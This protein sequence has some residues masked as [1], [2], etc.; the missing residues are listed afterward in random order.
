MNLA[1]RLCA[2]LLFSNMIGL[3][4]Q[5][6]PVYFHRLTM[7]DGLS[8]NIVN[9]A[10]ED[11][12]GFMW[13]ATDYG[14]NRFDGTDF[15]VFFPDGGP[16]GVSS[17]SSHIV[18]M[19]K[20]EDGKIW[21][22][23]M[24]GV[25]VFDTD[26]ESFSPFDMKTSDGHGPVGKITSIVRGKD[27]AIWV[28]DYASGIFRYAPDTGTL[29]RY[30]SDDGTLK[31]NDVMTICCDKDGTVWTGTL[32][33]DNGGLNR[34][35]E[36]SGAF[37]FNE[38][39]C[40]GGVNIIAETNTND[41]LVGMPKFG[42]D[43][44]NRVTG[45]SRHI[46]VIGKR[47]L[48]V[49]DIVVDGDVVWIATTSGLIRYDSGTEECQFM[50]SRPGIDN[51]LSSDDVVDIFRDSRG[52]LWFCTR[53]K[54]VN[55]LPYD[56]D[57]FEQ[58]PASYDESINS[59]QVKSFAEDSDGNIWIATR[60]GVCIFDP[61]AKRFGQVPHRGGSLHG[62]DV[63]VMKSFG[64]H[65]LLIG[66]FGRGLDKL[67]LVTGEVKLYRR[68]LNGLGGL[69]DDSVMS[70]CVGAEG[71]LLVGTTRGADILRVGDSG[72]GVLIPSSQNELISDIMEDSDFNIW[73]SSYGNGVYVL[74]P[75]TNVMENIRND[76]GNPERLASNM[77]TGLFLDSAS[78]IWVLTEGG[79]MTRMGAD[80]EPPCHFTVEDGLPNNIVQKMLED[81][82]G[83]LWIS[84]YDGLSCFDPKTQLFTNYMFSGS[85]VSNQFHHD[86]GL[87]SSDGYM[88]FGTND[89]FIRFR[90][91]N[92]KAPESDGVIYFT[93]L[94]V[95]DEAVRVGGKDSPLN[96]S[97]V[98]TDKIVL[99]HKQNTLSLTF[100]RLDIRW[101][102]N[103]PFLYKLEGHDPNWMTTNS[104]RISY[105]N[106]PSGKYRLLVMDPSF[107]ED[108]SSGNSLAI[109]IKPSPWFSWYAKFFYALL[110]A[111]ALYLV[112]SAVMKKQEEKKK[113]LLEELQNKKEKMLY[114]TKLAFFTGLA[115]EIKTPL[116]LVSSPFELLMSPDATKEEKESCETV[117]KENLNRLTELT[118]QML[119]ISLVEREGVIL[120]KAPTDINTLLEKVLS[121][122]KISFTQNALTVETDFPER[123][124]IANVDKE[125][126]I[127]IF[128][129]LLGNAEK[130]SAGKI[131]VR[132][133]TLGDSMRLS[134]WNNGA[135]IA[136]E[137]RE[138]IFETFYQ[139]PG[140]QRHGGVGVGLSLVKKYVSL[141][142]GKVYV[143]P[144]ASEGTEF[145][146]EIPLGMELT[147][148]SVQD[149]VSLDE[150]S[151]VS[152][153]SFSRHT[154][155]IVDDNKGMTKFLKA[156]FSKR[157]HVITANDGTTAWRL[158]EENPIDLVI[159]DV[160]M[161]DVDG[162]SLCRK[163]KANASTRTIPVLL[164]TAKTDSRS[165]LEGVEAGADAYIEKPF[166][167]ELLMAQVSNVLD[168]VA[169]YNARSHDASLKY[170]KSEAYSVK[171]EQFVKK[172]YDVISDNL[173]EQDLDIGF[174]ADKMNTS[175]SSLYRI[176]KNVTGRSP[177]EIIK[178]IRLDKA[179]SLLREG[180]MRV[181]EVCFYVGYTS[182]SYFAKSF[183]KKFGVLPK[184]YAQSFSPDSVSGSPDAA[185]DVSRE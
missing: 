130:Y 132:L 64:K 11:D 17:L 85:P 119:D 135:E 1:R 124:V 58:Y 160:M 104:N 37:V 79:G 25:F 114:D 150:N 73:M 6:T 107:S 49:N 147:G 39:S 133:S 8:H 47:D 179:A 23:T 91:E 42:V 144:E 117:I 71:N 120:N 2:I 57:S 126:F 164:L 20:V 18:S 106:L 166:S 35:D 171:D 102:D 70:I 105:S 155:L 111:S 123:H 69:N 178:D 168:K 143:N 140:S 76:E 77:A 134:V 116:T 89:G 154:I 61:V 152:G 31:S 145:V 169:M 66:Y 163:M 128:G 45:N 115:H 176:I 83:N 153:L 87:K 92:V 131:T 99:S 161:D 146:I 53:T 60:T 10:I 165:K 12:K 174:L 34:F 180:D 93:D 141:H 14:L 84:T 170:V 3:F 167:T 82:N 122:F 16:N 94:S 33:L 159:S 65:E 100:S 129:N 108:L 5:N 32:G 29:I 96:H 75:R 36:E 56:Y 24:S 7:E 158:L 157:Y 59:G 137:F 95:N 97:I 86:S 184:D 68:T 181:N 63:T 48:F 90:P 136:P 185:G 81:D 113:R 51:T 22:G 162:I 62:D 28:A 52:G 109:V 139:V 98:N 67:N 125:Q 50:N 175:R 138:K 26:L 19:L 148:A 183:F 55:Y 112:F 156:L 27:G 103:S 74:N 9:Q 4:G 101:N 182:S 13:F 110:L 142:L 172:L 54:G 121:T 41:L 173:P 151:D 72:F 88:Y 46:D 118:K 127:K 149:E 38:A 44:Y 21:V 40:V 80:G 78:N 177:G 43:S 15:K 30:S